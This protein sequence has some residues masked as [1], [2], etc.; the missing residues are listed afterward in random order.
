MEEIPITYRKSYEMFP[1]FIYRALV[2]SSDQGSFILMTGCIILNNREQQEQVILDMIEYAL[3]GNHSDFKL[4]TFWFEYWNTRK[5]RKELRKL[6]K[7]LKT[8]MRR[9]F[10]THCK[11]IAKGTANINDLVAYTMLDN[12]LLFELKEL[13]II[14]DMLDEYETYLSKSSF[15][16]A[17]LGFE[18]SYSDRYDFRKEF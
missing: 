14:E 9:L 6:I 5:K 16:V 8:S 17:L 4:I 12:L 11:K 1:P 7:C 3:A 10:K 13:E 15:I 18:R 2:L